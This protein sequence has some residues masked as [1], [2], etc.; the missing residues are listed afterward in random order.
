MAWIW[1]VTAHPQLGFLLMRPV[2]CCVLRCKNHHIERGLSSSQILEDSYFKCYYL[3][4][5][6][7]DS[8]TLEPS[9]WFSISLPCVSDFVVP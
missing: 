3:F 6:Q 1:E 8:Y 2:G 5:K 7:Y 9:N 4:H